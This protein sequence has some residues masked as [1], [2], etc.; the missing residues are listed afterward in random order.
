[1][2]ISI[3]I[4]LILQMD[5]MIVVP[6]TYL[7]VHTVISMYMYNV[8]VVYHNV[9]RCGYSLFQKKIANVVT[10]G[11]RAIEVMMVVGWL[12]LKSKRLL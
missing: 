1:M 11:V 9:Y 4:V 12:Y 10:I 7:H 6:C 2:Y 8:H 5:A 3:F